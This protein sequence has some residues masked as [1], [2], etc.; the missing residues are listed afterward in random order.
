MTLIDPATSL[1]A[2][3]EAHG[4][5]HVL[6]HFDALAPSVREAFLAQLGEVDLALVARL[7][8]P[9]TA[10]QSD[11]RSYCRARAGPFWTAE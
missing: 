10:R 2:A 9:A 5:A 1:R 3:F 4:Q 8:K 11:V 6:R 7:A